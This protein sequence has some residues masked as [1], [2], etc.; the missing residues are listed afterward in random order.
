MPSSR[1]RGVAILVSLAFGLSVAAPALAV[2]PP[3]RQ[4][5]PLP[6]WIEELKLPTPQTASLPLGVKLDPGLRVASGPKSVVVSLTELAAADVA[7]QGPTAQQA[8]VRRARAQQDAVIASAQRLDGNVRVLGRTGKATN[9]VML[10]IDAGTLAA[11]AADPAVVSIK[12]VIDYQMALDETVPYVGATAVQAAGFKGKGV[13]VAVLDS[14][15]DYTHAAFG[16]AGTLEAY[17]AAYGASPDDPLNTTTDGLFPTAKVVGGYDFVGET[18]DGA[19]NTPSLAPDPDP[20][21][22]GGHGTHVADIIGGLKGVAPGVS[23]YAVKVC[24]AQST[25]CSGV[26]LIEGMDFAVDPNGDGSTDDHVDVVNMSLGSDYGV[27]FDDDLSYAVDQASKVGV[28]TVAASGNGGDKPYIS[29][30]PGVAKSAL[31]VAETEVP[32]AVQFPL[33]VDSPDVIK[34]TYTNTTTVTWA[35]LG[36]GFSG[37]VT[38]I[39]RACPANSKDGDPSEDPYL[40]DPNGAAVVLI[41]RGACSV[42]LKVDR[43]AKDGAKA[44]LVGLVAAGDAYSFSYGG[45][46][47]FVPTLVIQDSLR[48]AIIANIAA[49]VHV[50]VSDAV[51]VSLVGS[52]VSSSSRGPAM[53]TN[54]LKP[55]IGAPG[56]SVSAEVGTGTDTTAF[57]GTSGATP[58]VAGAAALLRGAFPG[59]S[60]AEIKAV[61]MNTAET[62]IYTN[63]A[64]APGVLAPISRIGGG[65]LRVN[66]AFASPAA[67]WDRA[68]GTGALSFG[69]VD[70]SQ[71]VTTIVR[72][73]EVRN[74]TNRPITYAVRPTFRYA[75]DA[76]TGAVSVLAPRTVTV[77]SRRT[78]TFRVTL[79]I[80][81]SRL[82]PW[83]MNAGANGDNPVP[84]GLLEYDGYLNL[85]NLATSADD[86]DPLH[87]AWHVLPRLSDDVNATTERVRVNSILRWGPFAGLPGGDTSLRNRGA[88]AA[89]ID[90]YSLVGTSPNLPPS[91]AGANSPVVDLRAVGVQTFPVPANTACGDADS[92]VYV[93]AINTWERTTLAIA[94]N[95]FWVYLD[96]NHDGTADYVV[97]NADA[98]GPLAIDTGQSVTWAYNLATGEGDAWFYTDH[99]TNDGNTILTICGEQIGM[100]A[101]NFNQP[102]TMDV[103]AYD[104]YFT[105]NAT[106]AIE[107]IEVAPL[108]ERYLGIVG[109][110]G[111]SSGDI[112]PFSSEKLTVVDFGAAATNPSETGLLLVLDANRGDFRGGAP[113]GNEALLLRVRP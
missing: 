106:D 70:A 95:E 113:K 69:F 8:Q 32:S 84:L 56:A 66:R 43:A 4:T 30:T 17:E 40:A 73:V 35:D 111:Y 12:P 26:A 81:G 22:S 46:A 103:V 67:A 85:D 91:N 50:T 87:L 5:A 38:Y 59:R 93:I 105:G 79:R 19:A 89:Y 75:D 52:I 83:T 94:H 37:D 68:T 51:A 25:A 61:L 109:A 108:G 42:S 55:E 45:G 27:A 49:P 99:G 13:R 54:L 112:A 41:D 71:S 53:D 101:G 1:R 21:D 11:L 7:A 47:T 102:M 98:Y 28:L 18:W 72:E 77:G 24:S 88:G 2:D 10:S 16:G 9:V 97:L 39:G 36:S 6:Q 80:D 104:D 44:V 29:G 86:A 20:I 96:T 23:L 62:E 48:Q 100:N 82:R 92:F 76:A 58:M 110:A 14:G 64:T 74:Y 57:G 34:G 90:A 60:V 3:V 33:V 78:A 31:S 65:E 63:P 15:I 107:G